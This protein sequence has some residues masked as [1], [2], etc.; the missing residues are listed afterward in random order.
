[1]LAEPS[2]SL[3]GRGVDT[4]ASDAPMSWESADFEGAVDVGNHKVLAVTTA[5]YHGSASGIDVVR[6][7]WTVLTVRDGRIAWTEVYT[8]PAGA[9][10]AVGLSE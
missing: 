9:L 5:R 4:E 3:K 1:V 6:R 7:F 2:S 10:E 8:D